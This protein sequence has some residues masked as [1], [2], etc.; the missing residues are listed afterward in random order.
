MAVVNEQMVRMCA[1]HCKVTAWSVHRT[2]TRFG[3]AIKMGRV[4]AGLAAMLVARLR[5]ASV[6]YASVDD[7]LGGLFNCAYNLAARCLGMQIWL[8]HHSFLYLDETTRVMNW[9]VATAGSR[10][11]HILLC[12]DMAELMARRY[13][14]SRNHLVVPNAIAEPA[15]EIAR[16]ADRGTLAIGMLS[17]LT[18][19]KG[20]AEFV[21][22]LE[23]ALAR[24][25]EV[26]GILAGPAIGEDVRK[27]I[28][29]KAAVLGAR[30]D[31]RGPV[32]GEAKEYFFADIHLFVFPTKYRTETLPLV[33][34][35]SLVR[36]V[37][38]L[39]LKRGCICLF[40]RLKSA[41]VVA[42]PDTFMATA[43]EAID[44]LA[45]EPAH[46][47]ALSQLAAVEGKALNASCLAAQQ[48]LA[49]AL[50]LAGLGNHPASH[51]AQERLE[52]RATSRWPSPR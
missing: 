15:G 52:W 35:E 16:A 28:E 32:S 40:E 23:Q 34:S 47:A 14:R 27:F 13:P 29:E 19:E 38:V 42:D 1:R 24:G 41:I 12:D 30:L 6:L 51:K 50:T 7:N 8:H 46:R 44:K 4:V 45:R 17:N 5:G 18:F 33:L 11:R 21:A 25:A 43:N 36:A 9:V 22:I 48:S 3:L 26:K 31:W 49:E 39:T 2:P 20:V 10:A 37:P